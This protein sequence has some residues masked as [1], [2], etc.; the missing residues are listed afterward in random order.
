L[1]NPTGELASFAAASFGID[2]YSLSK[3]LAGF[4]PRR[5]AHDLRRRHQAGE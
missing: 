5:R 3:E 1:P 2:D 4:T